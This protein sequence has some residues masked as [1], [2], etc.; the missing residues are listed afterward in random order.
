MESL[1]NALRAALATARMA[2]GALVYLATRRTPAYAYQGMIRLFMISGGRSNDLFAQFITLI[3]RP[4][5][6]PKTSGVLG[7]FAESD[8]AR[9]TADLRVRGYH[10]FERRLPP[11]LCDQL[12]KFALTQP[13]QIRPSDED[14]GLDTAARSAVYDRESPQG[15][16]YDFH[17]ENLI[18]HPDVQRLMGD[19]SIIAV[20]QAYLGAKPVLDSVNLWWTTVSRRADSQAAQLYH[21]DMDRVRWLK[22]FIYLTDVGPENGPHCFVASSHRSGGIPSHLLSKGY[23]RHGDEEVA[24]CYSPDDLIE[25]TGPRGTILAEDTRGLHKGKP[26]SSGDRLI[27]EF[28]FSN[29]LFGASPPNVARLSVFHSKSFQEFVDAHRRIYGRWMPPTKAAIT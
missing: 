5:R 18:N 7:D 13:A 23:V 8:L 29:S 17:P 27:F 9:V 20:A 28:E 10:R 1:K 21:F 4:Y 6:L 12:L 22:F 3:H 15:I 16:V 14:S 11:D 25:F 24:A 2:Y 19:L 26:V